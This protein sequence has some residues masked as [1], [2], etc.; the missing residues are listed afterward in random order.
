MSPPVNPTKCVDIPNADVHNGQ[1][2]QIW[3]CNGNP[4]QN[5]Q[6]DASD[7]SMRV[8]KQ[9]NT[10]IDITSFQCP[11]G[12]DKGVW[13]CFNVMVNPKTKSFHFKGPTLE[14]LPPSS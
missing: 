8:S 13:S 1:D 5:F 14:S 3:D 12:P 6:Y 9:T 11:D 4:A 10:C 7:G 2:L